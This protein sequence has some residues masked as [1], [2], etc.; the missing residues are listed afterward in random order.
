MAPKLQET[1]START[2][3]EI[4]IEQLHF[5]ADIQNSIKMMWTKNQ[6]IAKQNGMTL[7]P[8]QFVEM[9]VASNVEDA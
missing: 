4:M 6:G 3:K 7:T 9:F 5:P 1:L 2:W 8:M